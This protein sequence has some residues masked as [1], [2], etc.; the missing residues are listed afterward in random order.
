MPD[1]I[2]PYLFLPSRD[3]SYWRK[4]TSADCPL[5][6]LGW[7]QRD[8]FQDPIP[9]SAHEGWVGFLVERGWPTLVLKD[10]TMPMAPNSFVLIGPQC[11][12]GWK[13][14]DAGGCKI[15]VWVW[16]KLLNRQAIAIGDDDYAK[17]RLDS[18]LSAEFVENHQSCRREVLRLDEASKSFLAGYQ[19]IFEANIL[20][21]ASRLLL[22]NVS[23]E[24]SELV[25]E[26]MSQHL[27]SKEP[28]SRLCDYLDLSPST[29]QRLFR[30]ELGVSPLTYFHRLKM[31]QAESLLSGG[32]SSIKEIAFQLG[33][34]HFNDF[35]RAFKKH[36]GR[37]PS[38]FRK[39]E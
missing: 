30:K 37:T 15:S 11:L 25:R 7:G 29:L 21:A 20:R 12:S 3:R 19:Q 38:G 18:Q 1:T 6:Y 8:F 4:D 27:D 24:F 33:Y 22:A 34:D 28:V 35:S 32:V 36:C 17:W 16:E 14:H 2:R 39:R 31:E 13:A 26:W 23:R 10:M 9:V 5:L